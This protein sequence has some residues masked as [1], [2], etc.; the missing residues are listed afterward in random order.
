VKS[1]L[2]RGFF[3]FFFT[4]VQQINSVAA[5]GEGLL[6][7]AYGLEGYTGRSS[8]PGGCGAGGVGCTVV[9]L[10]KVM[11]WDLAAATALA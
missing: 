11:M 10:P 8:L 1:L 2:F 3:P 9:H 4:F 5:D 6:G 7:R